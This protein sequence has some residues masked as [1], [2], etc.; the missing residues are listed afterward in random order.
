MPVCTSTTTSRTK[1][2]SED[3]IC[4]ARA[5]TAAGRFANLAFARVGLYSCGASVR[6]SARRCASVMGSAPSPT[7]MLLSFPPSL[8]G[9]TIGSNVVADGGAGGAS[10]ATRAGTR[11]PRRA[12]AAQRRGRRRR[13]LDALVP[14][15]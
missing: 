9:S 8:G 5:A 15:R 12:R 4:A 6:A 13:A 3:A 14:R 2:P 1:P 10:I 7:P 11:A